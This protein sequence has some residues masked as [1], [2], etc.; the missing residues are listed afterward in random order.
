MF[1]AKKVKSKKMS[2]VDNLLANIILSPIG[3]GIFFIVIIVILVLYLSG[4]FK[5]RSGFTTFGQMEPTDKAVMYILN[6]D[7]DVENYFMTNTQG[8]RLTAEVAD[9]QTETNLAVLTLTEP[10]GGAGIDEDDISATST[11][12]MPSVLDPNITTLLR[13]DR[14]YPA[15]LVKQIDVRIKSLTRLFRYMAIRMIFIQSQ[16][17]IPEEEME[18]A[19][20]YYAIARMILL[21][22]LEDNVNSRS[23]TRFVAGEE[24]QES[25]GTVSTVKTAP[26]ANNANVI[27][28]NGKSIAQSALSKRFPIVEAFGLW[29]NR[30]FYNGRW[31][32][33]DV[34]ALKPYENLPFDVSSN[35]FKCSAITT[36]CTIETLS[37]CDVL[38][39]ALPT[40][41]FDMNALAEDP[42]LALETTS[43]YQKCDAN[44]LYGWY[45]LIYNYVGT[46]RDDFYNQ[47]YR[48]Y[49]RTLGGT[50]IKTPLVS[51]HWGSKGAYTKTRWVDIG[52]RCYHKDVLKKPGLKDPI[53]YVPKL[54]IS[55]N[56]DIGQIPKDMVVGK[57][58]SGDKKKIGAFCYDK[59]MRSDKLAYSRGSSW[60]KVG[61]KGFKTW[62]LKVDS[63]KK[64][65][66]CLGKTAGALC[67]A[68]KSDPNDC[69]N[70]YR[71][72]GPQTC[73]RID[74]CT[75]DREFNAG[76]CYKKCRDGYKGAATMCVADKPTVNCRLRPD[77]Y[78]LKSS[79]CL[80]RVVNKD[81][82]GKQLYKCP[83]KRDYRSQ[84][85][86][87]NKELTAYPPNPYT[88]PTPPPED[89]IQMFVSAG[90][91]ATDEITET[92]VDM[93][94]DEFMSKMG[95]DMSQQ[96]PPSDPSGMFEP[97]KDTSDPSANS[98][99]DLFTSTSGF[100]SKFM[101]SFA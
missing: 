16:E 47:K 69:P 92:G 33:F 24:V 9:A 80:P 37:M 31:Y 101:A 10:E 35:V 85:Q 61:K 38:S 17:K 64:G 2:A 95:F 40:Q 3:L 63:A 60:K 18:E 36:N 83:S 71:S 14:T 87:Y 57:G 66:T 90:E 73:E 98:A 84:V 78:R 55:Y 1:H 88:T 43:T 34:K 65:Y 70:G 48:D 21:G 4:Y 41:L 29:T 52:R 50:G 5:K 49:T 100:S 46:V 93:S 20:S 22:H 72:T 8:D 23:D 58:C 79:L 54:D 99:W 7:E 96:P 97:V 11:A 94:S 89:G 30:I 45:V 76:L 74:K 32:R 42:A 25:N 15:D 77:A 59:S 39:Y 26:T 27:L 44:T 13:T 68:N 28:S 51:F 19:N 62:K 81:R 82:R 91:P 75:D 12:L 56:R 67:V 86:T 53:P 6:T